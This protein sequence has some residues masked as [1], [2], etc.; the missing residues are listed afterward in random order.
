M[1]QA[2]IRK[3]R[4]FPA[5]VPAPVVNPGC[6]LIKVVNSCIS[7]GTELA[8]VTG[9]GKSV[10]RQ[11]LEQPQKIAKAMNMMRTEGLARTIAKIH[12]HLEAG[13]ATGYSAA[14]IVLAVGEGVT[15]L[16]PGDR[17]AAAG[18]GYANNAEYIDV[19]RNLVMP[20][21]EGLSFQ[22]AATVTLGGIAMQGVRRAAPALGEFV[23][24]YGVGI[25]GM[26]ALR[27]C[28][29]SGARVMAL[30]ID[31]KR[32]E[33]ARAMGAELCCNASGN[34]IQAEIARHTAG[35]LADAVI[36][37]AATDNTQA[38][39]NAFALTRRKG[40]LVMVGVWGRELDRN[41]IYK[42]EI[43]FLI[44]TS[45][46][47]GRYDAEYEEG[48]RDYPYAYVRW[49][50]NRNMS[51]YL[52]ILS[53]GQMDTAPLIHGIYPIERVEDAYAALQS[54]DKPMLV[55]LD[56]GSGLPQFETQPARVQSVH[57][58]GVAHTL[59]GPV[60]VAVVVAG[61][62][63]QGM[64]LPNLKKLKELFTIR[65]VCSR[66]GAKAQ[67]VATRYEAAYAATDYAEVL[68]DPEVD[69]VILCTRHNL[70]GSQVLQALQAGKHVLVE[71]P[72][73]IHEEELRAIEHF[74]T[75]LTARSGHGPLLAVGFN[76]RFSRY[77]LALRE[78]TA[79]SVSPLFIRYRMNAGFL[80]EDHW[81]HG[82]EGGGRI[83]GEACHIID[84][85]RSLVSG[86]VRS[87]RAASLHP[88]GGA[89]SA[90]DN[91]II[92]LEYADGSIASLE[93]FSTGSADLPKEYLEAHFDGKSVLMDNFQ[94]LKSYGVKAP[95][96]T[97]ASP[98]KGQLDMLKAVGRCITGQEDGWPIALEELLE[99]TA[100]TLAAR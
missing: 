11:A 63:A 98:D 45:Y 78:L 77:L 59:K 9:S 85:A 27:M 30:D 79:G 1:K 55:L 96:L 35:R 72:L 16:R 100:I 33:L 58:P 40:R 10:I 17:V 81:T 95:L 26:L 73:C 13:Q 20:M 36:F 5:E 65:A 29:L 64:H 3:G 44:S 76:R 91:K 38:L 22:N 42:K 8:G 94:S 83:V 93:Y 6:V 37:C 47:P 88:H 15:D 52:R 24:I 7:A 56:Y 23:L 68:A 84:A 39:S 61:N 4:V 87:V 75:G 49:T 25:L 41:D 74:Y 32:L 31:D 62:Y 69:L 48:G 50:E 90:A 51:E 34:N 53:S 92:T 71:K 46:G 57:I 99:T 21:P 28:L 67:A 54:H 12:G 97:D 86:P 70:H 66:T 89:Y 14:G 82:P 18:A 60:R 2:L 43:D 80:P 19:P